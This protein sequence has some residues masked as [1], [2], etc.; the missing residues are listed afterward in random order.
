[1]I[2]DPGVLGIGLLQ[3]PAELIH[4]LLVSRPEVLKSGLMTGRELLLLL[5][6]SNPSLKALG[7]FPVLGV[8]RFQLCTSLLGDLELL[9]QL[10]ELSRIG[11]G[12]CEPVANK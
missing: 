10:S 2:L 9:R 3:L 5:P 4:L 8:P 1:L 11:S 12:S 7:D 6:Q